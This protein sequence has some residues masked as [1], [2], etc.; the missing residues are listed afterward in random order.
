MCL[1]SDKSGTHAIPSVQQRDSNAAGGFRRRFGGE[2]GGCGGE[3]VIHGDEVRFQS[4][5]PAHLGSVC[6]APKKTEGAHRSAIDVVI[7]ISFVL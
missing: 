5:V 1:S 2:G 3:G 7:S 6:F 4:L